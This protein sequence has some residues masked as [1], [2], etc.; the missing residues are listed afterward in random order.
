[1]QPPQKKFQFDVVDLK[2]S[3]Y[4]KCHVTFVAVLRLSLA[5]MRAETAL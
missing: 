1:M 5:E 4:P 3:F 2:F